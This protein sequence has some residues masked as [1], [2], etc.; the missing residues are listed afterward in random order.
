MT[1]ARSP[2]LAAL[3]ACS[4]IAMPAMAADPPSPSR[5]DSRIRFVTYN[6]ADVVPVDTATGVVTHI[7]LEE[8]ETVTTFALGDAEAWTVKDRDNHIFI[9][10]KADH[11]DTNLVVITDRR[12]YNFWLAYHRARPVVSKG[13]AD[14]GTP[15]TGKESGAI[16]Q[17]SFH[18]PESTQKAKSK[19][20][21][22]EAAAK[23][24]IEASF[25]APP[26]SAST[27]YVMA[28]DYSIAPLNVWDDGRFT[29]FKFQ[30]NRD[31]PAI[32]MVDA[33]GQETIVNRNSVGAASDVVVTQKVNDQWRLRLGNQA[34]TVRNNDMVPA[35]DKPIVTRPRYEDNAR[36]TGTSSPAVQRI[37]KGGA[38]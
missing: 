22:E 10:P 25:S 24:K 18:Y 30:A 29:Y 9:K 3:V 38:Q 6:P 2:F 15:K 11:A 23:A 7:A 20:E 5:F 19:A 28:G 1:L 33:D 8:G 37:I 21:A 16:Y 14:L 34:L 26:A 35:R 13:K 27:N 17:L 4:A 32:Y 12:T 31:I 36:Y